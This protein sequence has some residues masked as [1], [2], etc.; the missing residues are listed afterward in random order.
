MKNHCIKVFAC[1]GVFFSSSLPSRS[2]DHPVV[3]QIVY[4]AFSMPFS[5]AAAL[6][7]EAKTDKVLYDQ[8]L[9]GLGK[10]EV[11]QEKLLSTRCL[12]GQRSVA[13]HISEYIYPTGFEP[14]ELPNSIGGGA[15]SK[16]GEKGGSST[17]APDPN[18]PD[19]KADVVAFP[20]TPATPT[21][22]DTR[23][24]G[25]VLE[26]EPQV[27]STFKT[28]ELRC[29]VEH[30]TLQKIDIWGQGLSEAGMPRFSN[31]EI[32]SGATQSSGVPLLIG[33]ITPS[34]EA[35]GEGNPKRVWFAFV[36]ST[37]IEVKE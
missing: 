18:R 34:D 27:D 20:A 23:L 31:Q 1:C 24:L 36:T 4:E 19:L 13:S 11:V 5:D 28:V 15:P 25:D 16:K 30:V 35:L 22:F 26:V 29:T 12:P 3:I 6:R 2:Q 10:G 8:L 37:V 33:T 7:R 32:K 21:T 14:P 17:E 9:A